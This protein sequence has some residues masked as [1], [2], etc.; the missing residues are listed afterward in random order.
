MATETRQRGR[1]RFG[2]SARLIG[3]RGEKREVDIY[4]NNPLR[5]SGLTFFQHQMGRD[6]I[7]ANRGTS[8][9][10]VVKNPSWL[11]PYFGTIVVGLGLLVQFLIHLVGFLRKPRA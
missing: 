11:A 8:V 1:Q 6:D 10:Q 3:K 4:M 7:D 9:L 5:Y 2:Q